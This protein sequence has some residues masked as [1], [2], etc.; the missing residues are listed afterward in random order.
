MALETKGRDSRHARHEARAWVSRQ[1]ARMTSRF[2]C[3]SR[4]RTCRPTFL[5]ISA[6]P[7]TAIA[8][9]ALALLSGCAGSSAT[10]GGDPGNNKLHLL[11]RDPIFQLLPPNA[12]AEGVL[13]LTA[14]RYIQSVFEGGGWH[15]PAVT[16]R[17]DSLASPQSVFTFYTDRALTTGWSPTGSRNV[18]G[19]PQVWNK[20]IPGLI[21]SLTLTDLDLGTA[22]SGSPST[23]V[24]NGS[25]L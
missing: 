23:Y 18:L 17:F 20:S 19:F 16:L 13:R 21:A 9:V 3:R 15:G 8:M 14:A 6:I 10:P 12:H 1:A 4:K 2:R 11:A 24:L 22:P 25:A 5:G 7:G